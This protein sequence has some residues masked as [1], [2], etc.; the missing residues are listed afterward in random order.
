MTKRKEIISF[1]NEFL[2]SAAIQ[3]KSANGLQVEGREEI[4]KIVFGVSANA[5]LFKAA[6]AHNAD[7]VIV[8]HG[9]FWGTQQ[10]LTGPFKKRVEILIKNDINL[11]AWHLPL[12]MHKDIGN[13]AAMAKM[14]GLKKIRPFGKYHGV[15]I[16]YCG[17]LSK[18]QNMAGI[19]K[20]LGAQHPAA[21]LNFGPAKIETVAI[22]SGGGYDMLPQAIEKGIDLFI[23]GSSEEYVHETAR[24]GKINYLG[25]GH[26]NS[27]TYGIKNLM[28]IIQK[29]F[30]IEVYFV[31]IPNPL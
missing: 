30:K 18:P 2:N 11:A 20:L 26:Y 23:T 12:D 29:R 22:V 16:G 17:A 9:L 15:E 3:D 24:E 8:H 31:D 14:L 27:E 25:L 6:A 28:Q 13:N 10:I 1:V 21:E 4:K 5:E 19:K 7:M